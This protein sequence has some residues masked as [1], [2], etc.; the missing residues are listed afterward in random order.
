MALCEIIPLGIVRADFGV[1][2]LKRASAVKR[3]QN[4]SRLPWRRGDLSAPG[5]VREGAAGFGR[6]YAVDLG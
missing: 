4:G 3:V 1:T 5:G 6:D 2:K